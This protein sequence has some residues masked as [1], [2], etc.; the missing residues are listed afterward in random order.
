[1]SSWSGITRAVSEGHRWQAL[2]VSSWASCY[3]SPPNP[4]HCGSWDYA[5]FKT[6]MLWLRE[7]GQP[8]QVTR[9]VAELVPE[10]G[11][12]GPRPSLPLSTAFL[13]HLLWPPLFLHPN[14]PHLLKFQLSSRTPG[15]KSTRFG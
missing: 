9:Q 3:R 2:A 10:T 15:T 14:K 1:M 5:H 12:A 11:C 4:R 7:L 13:G 6:R 8:A